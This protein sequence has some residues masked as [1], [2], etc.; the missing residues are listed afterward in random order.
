MT[1]YCD[2]NGAEICLKREKK[3]FR[4]FLLTLCLFGSIFRIK[5]FCGS[6]ADIVESKTNIVHIRYYAE[7]SAIS[8]AFSILY[9]A[10]RH[11]GSN[12]KP[13]F[14]D[15]FFSFFSIFSNNIFSLLFGYGK[16]IHIRMH[17]C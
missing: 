7:A 3:I 9:T 16:F 11:K 14:L 13:F 4:S 6:M 5:N 8:S 10:F 2:D 17:T 15:L 1:F 12:G